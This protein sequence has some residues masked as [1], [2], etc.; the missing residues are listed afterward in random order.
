[1]P[2]FTHSGKLLANLTAVLSLC[3]VS[4][5]VAAMNPAYE[6]DPALLQD[7]SPIPGVSSKSGK[8]AA[9]VRSLLKKGTAAVA[10]R[11]YTVRPGDNLFK[12]LMRDYGLTN[13][14]AEACLDETLRVN[15]ISN[16]RRLKVGRRIIIPLIPTRNVE[17]PGKALQ[18][19]PHSVQNETRAASFQTLHL[20][21]PGGAVPDP[22]VPLQV[23]A[24]W[25]KLV[26]MPV[27]ERKPLSIQSATFSLTLDPAR[28]PN[29]TA[30][31]GA[32][33]VVDQHNTIPA[34][35]KSLIAEKDPTVRIISGSPMNSRRFLAQLLGVAGFYSVEEDFVL[36]FGD[37]PKLKVH[38]DFKIEK[39]PESLLRQEVILL[40]DTKKTLPQPLTNFLRTEGFIAYEPFADPLTLPTGHARG[41]VRQITAT[42]RTEMVDAILN[43]LAVTPITDRRVDVFAA[44]NNG[45]TLSVR[46][47]RYFERDGKR[48]I[49]AGFDGDPVT[50]TLYRILETKGLRVVILDAKDDFRSVSEKILASLQVPGNYAKHML[51]ADNGLNYSLQMSGFRLQGA[52]VPGGSL[53]LTNRP[54][55]KIIRELLTGNGYDV[56]VK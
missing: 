55:D 47:E 16:I 14:E 13:A 43:A 40:N 56:Q 27:A 39:T 30:V 3:I 18:V 51:V 23:R 29:F 25:N 35:V 9:K 42:S 8:R 36:E 6:L 45:I 12:I 46:A 7:S 38:A 10:V 28:Y 19:N 11:E 54:L 21:A 1:M 17:K 44:D 48:Y 2:I 34:L 22:D 32:R 4:V 20:E 49:I 53:F 24:F 50:Y 41:P 26:P 15:N 33:I 37:D 31:D 52:G 5:A